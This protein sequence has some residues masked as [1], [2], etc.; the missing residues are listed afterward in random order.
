[1]AVA[2]GFGSEMPQKV[3]LFLRQDVYFTVERIAPV[4]GHLRHV[5]VED[6]ISIRPE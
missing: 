4:V 3:R 5:T 1:M 6:Q 2:V